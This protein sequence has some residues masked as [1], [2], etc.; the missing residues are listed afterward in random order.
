MAVPGNDDSIDCVILYNELISTYIL[1][2]KFGFILLWYVNIRLKKRLLR[3]DEWVLHFQSVSR[4]NFFYGEL[5][6]VQA[7]GRRWLYYFHLVSNKKN[8]MI[9]W[10]S[11]KSYVNKIFWFSKWIRSGFKKYLFLSSI[12]FIKNILWLR[13]YFKRKRRNLFL[14][15]RFLNKFIFKRCSIFYFLNTRYLSRFLRFFSYS[16]HF[17]K[18]LKLSF[19]Y[20]ITLKKSILP[21]LRGLGSREGRFFRF[22]S[23]RIK[24]N[25]FLSFFKKAYFCVLFREFSGVNYVQIVEKNRFNIWN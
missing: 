2:C 5:S 20:K 11:G 13:L 19:I 15:D 18:F 12:Y 24:Y 1:A 16:K 9:S 3:F 6:L 8:H 4:K 10:Y 7:I 21:L 14:L 23:N 17:K 25:S 22:S